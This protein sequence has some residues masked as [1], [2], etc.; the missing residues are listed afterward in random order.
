MRN[1]PPDAEP[2]IVSKSDADASPIVSVAVWSDK[3]DQL[4]LSGI[5]NDMIKERMQTIP[6]VSEVR[7]WGEKRYSMRLWISPAKLAAYAL[8]PRDVLTALSSENVE[9]PTGRIEGYKTELTVRTMGRLTNPDEFGNLIIKETGGNVVR[10]RDVGTVELGAENQR[11][12]FRRDGIPMVAV[13]VSP[14]PGANH[15]AIA[16]EF[17]KR[18]DQIQKDLPPDIQMAIGF[19]VTKYIRRSIA[20]VE[21]TLLIAFALVILVIFLFLRD[22]RTTLIPVVAIPIS[23]IGAF[24]V[25]LLG[26]VLAIGIVVDDAIVVLENIYSKLERGMSA[27]EAAFKGSSEIYLAIISTTIALVIIFFQIVSVYSENLVL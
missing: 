5:A 6:G 24:F 8:T 2:P 15:V 17:Y 16:D 21:E 3:R 10:F 7:I 11:T 14:Q 1:L 13:A 26:L 4:E 18:V 27:S 20:E 9:L 12:I 25:I 23:I 19:D 22:W